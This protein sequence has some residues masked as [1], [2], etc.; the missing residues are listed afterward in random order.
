MRA[1]PTTALG[2]CNMLTRSTLFSTYAAVSGHQ[3][4][5]ILSITIGANTYYFS[6][7][8]MPRGLN[9]SS[10][11]YP[12]LLSHGPATEDLDVFTKQWQ[13]GDVAFTISDQPFYPS[14]G[15][16]PVRASELLTDINGASCILYRWVEGITDI[17]DCLQIFKGDI[18][19]PMQVSRA[20]I[21]FTALDRS[22]IWDKT[23]PTQRIKDNNFSTLL[24]TENGMSWVPVIYGD[25]SVPMLYGD[26]TGST[27]LTPC[28]AHSN[29]G[30]G[31][32]Y[33]TATLGAAGS[34][35][36]FDIGAK[37]LVP[38]NSSAYFGLDEVTALQ[39]DGSGS[40]AFPLNDTLP[41][42]FNDETYKES[43]ANRAKINDGSTA[44]QC[45]LY[46]RL[47]DD[48]NT[49]VGRALWGIKYD[50]VLRDLI[51]AGGWMRFSYTKITDA[52]VVE[53]PT[54]LNG[55]LYYGINGASDERTII[56]SA[57]KVA[58]GG[59]SVFVWDS[60]TLQE[61]GDS[62]YNKGEDDIQ[63]DTP[64]PRLAFALEAT[65]GQVGSAADTVVGNQQLILVGE[66]SVIYH[67]LTQRYPATAWANTQGPAYGTVGLGLGR[68]HGYSGSAILEDPALMVEALYRKFLSLGDSDIDTASFDSAVNTNVKARL[69]VTESTLVSDI[70][71]TLAEQSTFAIVASGAGKLRC[72]P[73][74]NTNPTVSETIYR[75]QLVNDDIALTK[76]SF[77][78]NSLNIESRWQAEYS[79]FYDAA[80]FT[81]SSSIAARRTRSASY[82]WKN[83]AGSSVT[84]VGQHYVNSTNGLWSKE[85]P[86]VSFATPGF[87]HSH[88]QVGDWISLDTGVDALKKCYG[89]SWSGL[90][91]LITH[92]SKNEDQTEITA[93]K[94]Y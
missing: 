15:A 78:V 17:A 75:T 24:Y 69:C 51:A 14:T 30:T 77:I 11:I 62:T 2:V 63:T 48:G 44:T 31:L 26:E 55:Y 79:R 43:D 33:I 13:V 39:I 72:I 28:Y 68:T 70:V 41:G 85:H 12:M 21:Q 40:L 61:P 82:Q 83:I 1:D 38:M 4:D 64:S 29:I 20:S 80:S 92:I 81:D 53:N 86:V 18:L 57:T 7:R 87:M 5:E 9:T 16:A 46:D 49:A 67:Y 60:T 76:T 47:S 66:S 59:S 8:P 36:Y 65:A 27:G 22:K 34:T 45:P 74:N 52:A 58:S 71:R 54:A 25:F 42:L 90:K 50:N 3:R 23:I 10:P 6:M 84:H 94:L 37:T 91:L 56:G 32:G 89:T 35:V 19:A 73:L 93:T 88:L